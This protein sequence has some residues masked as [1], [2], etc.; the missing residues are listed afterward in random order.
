M[1]ND[2]GLR[3]EEK[4]D[5]DE[6]ENHVRRAGFDGGA[7]EIREHNKEDRGE[8]EVGEAEFFAKGEGWSV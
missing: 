7:E 4:G 8:D 1:R 6:P 3:D 5:G 2:E